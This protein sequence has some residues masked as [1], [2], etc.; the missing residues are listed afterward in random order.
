MTAVPF[1]GKAHAVALADDLALVAAGTGGL[2]V[3]SVVDPL[4]PVLTGSIQR[5]RVRGELRAVKVLEVAASGRYAVVRVGTNAGNF[6]LVLDLAS[7]GFEVIGEASD[8]GPM[9]LQGKPGPGALEWADPHALAVAA[10][11]ATHAGGNGLAGRRYT[12]GRL[13]GAS[14]GSR[15]DRGG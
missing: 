4:R 2:A 15:G 11:V 9:A 10:H 12:Q 1:E 3:F 8:L 14:R 6:T 7:P 5:M 13:G